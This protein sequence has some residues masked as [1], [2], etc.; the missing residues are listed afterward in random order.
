M[1]SKRRFSQKV[2][3]TF[4]S[5]TDEHVFLDKFL[6]ERTYDEHVDRFARAYAKLDIFS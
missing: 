6:D 4:K 1:S 2:P 3:I 5:R